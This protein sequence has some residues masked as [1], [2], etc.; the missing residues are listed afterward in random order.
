MQASDIL[1][2]RA[3]VAREQARPHDAETIDAIA[4]LLDA[5]IE[6]DESGMVYCRLCRPRL[7]AHRP[8]CALAAA[9]RAITGESDV[10][11]E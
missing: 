8:D 7:Y 3:R 4:D 11:S 10:K 5:C 9:E 1:R 6:S 2:D